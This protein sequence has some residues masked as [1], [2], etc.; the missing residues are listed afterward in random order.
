MYLS[1]IIALLSAG[2]NNILI[3]PCEGGELVKVVVGNGKGGTVVAYSDDWKRTWDQTHLY[4]ALQWLNANLGY[5]FT[6]YWSDCYGQY[7]NFLND[8]WNNGPWDLAAVDHPACYEFGWDAWDDM[9]NWVNAGGKLVFSEFDL[10]GDQ[11]GSYQ[12]LWNLLG[13]TGPYTDLG[14][15]YNIYVWNTTHPITNYTGPGGPNPIPA[16]FSG[17]WDDWLDDGDGVWKY[18]Q[19]GD[20]VMLIGGLTPTYQDGQA[21]ITV[22]GPAGSWPCN[23]VLFSIL[24]AEWQDGADTDAD[25]MNDAV[26]LWR[27]AIWAVKEGCQ[28]LIEDET[29]PSIPEPGKLIVKAGEI[30]WAGQGPVECSA[31][32]P[33]GRLGWQGILEPGKGLRLSDGLWFVRAE[34]QTVKVFVR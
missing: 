3:S 20:T 33:T 7:A 29:A 24:L 28:V 11:Q 17:Y 14:Y 5:T 8:M 1:V 26:E 23:T 27:N 34:G 31:Y 9:Y 25:G 13:A 30:F 18:S 19:P 22:K 12:Q 4:R 15:A 16:V 21:L 2:D 6:Y 10:D 32:D